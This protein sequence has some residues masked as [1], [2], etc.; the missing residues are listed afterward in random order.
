MIGILKN[1]LIL[2]MVPRDARS[3]KLERILYTRKEHDI[4][5]ALEVSIRFCIY[6]HTWNA[7]VCVR[8]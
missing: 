1:P 5:W 6:I 2:E 4:I 8:E 3:D 7:V